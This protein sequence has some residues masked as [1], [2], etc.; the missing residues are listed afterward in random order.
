MILVKWNKKYQL[1]TGNKPYLIESKRIFKSMKQVSYFI[2]A[3]KKYDVV[4]H[5]V[6]EDI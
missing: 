3:L 1:D 2:K 6:I 5:P 4:G